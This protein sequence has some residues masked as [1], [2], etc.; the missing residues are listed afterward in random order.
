MHPPDAGALPALGVVDELRTALHEHGVA[1][2]IAPPGTG[3]TTA[4]PPLL[5]STGG[6]VVLVEPRRLAARS[7]VARMSHLAGCGVGE[8]FG[9]S[10][11][12]ER[13]VSPAMTVEAVTPGL[14]LRRLQSDPELPGVGTVVL[15]EF[16]ERS[17]DMD[18]CLTLLCDVRASLR[19]D[20]RIVVMS[21]TLDAGPV[22]E[23]LGGAP[24]V[25]AEAVVH[26]VEVRHRPGSAHDP[27]ESRA[28]AVVREALSAGPGDVLVFLPGRA[29]L[30]RAARL[31]GS[32]TLAGD[33]EVLVLHGG[34]G[35]AEQDRIVAGDPGGR[36]RV[37]LSTS[38]AESSITVPGV[39]IVVDA[40]R[41]RRVSVDPASGLPGLV[42][43][44]ASRASAEQRAGRAGRTAPGVAYRLWSSED[45]R[46][47]PSADTP[48][49]L[50]GDLAPLVLQVLRWGESDPAALAWLD[51]PPDDALRRART[52]LRAL[53]ATD[54][55]GQLTAEG[56]AM[57]DL[58]FHP[59][60]A[61]VVARGESLGCPE[62]A[63]AV[64]AILEAD[65][66]GGADLVDRLTQLAGGDADR[67]V[68]EAHRQWRRTL[69]VDRDGWGDDWIPQVGRLLVAGYLDRVAQRRG[70]QRT[71]STGRPIVVFQ[72]R[73]GG[74][75]AVPETDRHLA[76]SEWIVVAGVDAGRNGPGRL[77][78]VVS[79][80][81]DTVQSFTD[82]AN[83][84]DEV[85]WDAGTGTLVARR[86][87]MLDAITLAEMPLRNPA[88]EL[89]RAAW[90][91]A[92]AD[93]GP[94]I[95]DGYERTAALRSRVGFLAAH[96][97]PDGVG[98]PDWSEEALR[99]DLGSWLGDDLG[100]ISSL[101]QLRRLDVGSKLA[102]A[103]DWQ[104]RR[105]LDELA[106]TEITAAGGR[107]LRLAYGVIDGDPASVLTQVRLGDLIGTDTHPRVAGGAV[108][109]T[110]ELLS[111]AGRP[112]QRTTD[113]PGFWRGSYA[114]VRSDL[115]GRYPKHP[116]P[117]RPW[118][119]LPARRR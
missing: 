21:A 68:V 82:E 59:R 40:G 103:L 46:H 73:S 42:T 39:R 13:R 101:E 3:K 70:G 85:R 6:R 66:A 98:W 67:A 49:I 20:L 105:A 22:A 97:L 109:V 64:A 87:R 61:A 35:T 56:R 48:E 9:Y 12:G 14:L 92:L 50:E 74:E 65:R 54:D 23:V 2:L 110:I 19:D 119:P 83:D 31:L 5:D 17:I 36:R 41:R 8:R 52:L 30:G 18:L 99:D 90:R 115:R 10:V 71:D 107:R 104:M 45:E 57:A 1:V 55:R 47:R 15:D 4:V 38:L 27:I 113:L 58:G 11:R 79:L 32:T 62:L 29:E 25:R 102:A 34:L 53:G 89:V 78:L 16:H 100:G 60:L 63:A 76:E 77:L 114:A 112:V 33:P 72:L 28:A 91:D 117:E 69:G 116:W 37:V 51:P 80:D 26:P 75:V 7:A 84:V 111:P 94:A 95:I 118:E 96:G 88:P 108:P 106:P 43:T 86:R 24:L 93:R 44:A 81:T